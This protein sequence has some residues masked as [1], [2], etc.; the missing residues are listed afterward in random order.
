[1]FRPLLVDDS[2]KKKKKKK[3]AGG[4]VPVQ[5]PLLRPL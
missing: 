5:L 4:M 3:K 1:M 2:A